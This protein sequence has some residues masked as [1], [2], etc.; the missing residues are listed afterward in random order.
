MTDRRLQSRCARMA[1]VSDA[2]VEVAIKT[3][4]EGYESDV[5]DNRYPAPGFPHAT[6]SDPSEYRKDSAVRVSHADDN[7]LPAHH[8]QDPDLPLSNPCQSRA[9]SRTPC[10]SSPPVGPNTAPA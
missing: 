5:K 6:N 4:A 8:T 10:L 3:R 1:I 9:F 7:P 2:M